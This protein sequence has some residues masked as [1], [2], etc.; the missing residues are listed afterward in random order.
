MAHA[1][2][3]F[4]HVRV[5]RPPQPMIA[6]QLDEAVPI[7]EQTPAAHERILGQAHPDTLTSRDNLA[8][9]YKDSWRLDE[10]K[11]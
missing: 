7:F 4:Q 3:S 11:G 1:P 2:G 5:Q 10:A 6:R 8:I 9:A